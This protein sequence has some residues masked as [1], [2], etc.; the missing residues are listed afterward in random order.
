VKTAKQIAD[1]LGIDK[2]RVYRFI[3]ANCFT[4]KQSDRITQYYDEAVE[5]AIKQHFT[6]GTASETA[7]SDAV[8]DAVL[9]HYEAVFEALKNELEAKNRQITELT[10]ALITAQQTVTTAQAL[11]AGTMQK[12]LTDKEIDP[13]QGFFARIFGWRKQPEWQAS[14]Y[15]HRLQTVGTMWQTKSAPQD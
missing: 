12:N 8:S 10:T 14:P 6:N 13:P 2:Q 15:P 11:H 7:S 4:V 3:K 9:K 5:K 1:E